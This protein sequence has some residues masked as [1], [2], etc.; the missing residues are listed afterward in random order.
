MFFPQRDWMK[1]QLQK[2]VMT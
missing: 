1:T 2:A